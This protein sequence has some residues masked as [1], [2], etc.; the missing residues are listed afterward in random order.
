MSDELPPDVFRWAIRPAPANPVYVYPGYETWNDQPHPQ[1]SEIGFPIA[2]RLAFGFLADWGFALLP[3]DSLEGAGW[4]LLYE[5]ADSVVAVILEA[6]RAFYI[7]VAPR[8]VGSVAME[9]VTSSPR[10]RQA[11][12]A[13][14]EPLPLGRPFLVAARELACQSVEPGPSRDRGGIG[15]GATRLQGLQQ[16][17]ATKC[18]LRRSP[19]WEERC[20]G[21]IENLPRV[22]DC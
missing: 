7:V 9:G 1:L 16:S 11:E 12:V 20:D 3:P 22:D 15:A 4:A 8:P 6:D 21:D 5:R 19:G 17:A 2:V 14:Q 13:G 10:R 18:Y